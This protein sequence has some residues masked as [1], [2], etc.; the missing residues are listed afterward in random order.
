MQTRLRLEATV[1][2][3]TADAAAA[4]L[5]E[6]GLQQSVSELTAASVE[7]ERLHS[8]TITDLHAQLAAVC[9]ERD[10]R[11]HHQTAM[12]AASTKVFAL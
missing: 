9:A 3:L 4:H 10:S 1:T 11:A 8:A 12:N 2:E 7:R 6:V 5:R